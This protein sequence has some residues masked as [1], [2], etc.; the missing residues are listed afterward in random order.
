MVLG[1]SRYPRLMLALGRYS[2][3]REMA[4][5]GNFLVKVFV[6]LLW[7]SILLVFYQTIFAQTDLVAGWTEGEYLF[8]VGCY[9]AMGGIIETLFMENCNEFAELVRSG[10][11]DFFLLQP[12]DEQFLISC[13]SIEWASAPNVLMG[14]GVMGVSLWRMGWAF[15]PLQLSLFLVLFGSGVAI[16][17]SFLLLLTSTSVWLVRNQSL[18]ELWWLLSSLMR[19]PRE[20]FQGTWATPLGWVF[21]FLVPIMLVIN[22][23]AGLMVR[24]LEPG[25]AVFMIAAAFVLLGVSRWFFRHALTRYRSASS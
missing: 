24:T 10:D 12:I 16:S 4:F 17:Y 11:L 18:Y 21:T 25:F 14:A 23:P 22:V 1:A 13:R 15:D 5:R 7:L 2:L 9:F 6:E 20:I 3:A 8:F 19:Y